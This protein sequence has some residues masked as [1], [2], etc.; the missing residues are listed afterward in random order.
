MT[1]VRWPLTGCESCKMNNYKQ[2]DAWKIAM[3]LINEVYKIVKE[4]PKEELYALTTQTK[5]AAVSVAANIAEGAGRQYKKDTLQFFHISRGSLYELETL[6]IIA[7]DNGILSNTSF[8]NV[9]ALLEKSLQV[10]NGLIN[11]YERSNLK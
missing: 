6:L 2:L 10:L 1:V 7:L 9:S 11:Y 4:Y 8:Q 3:Q 5:R